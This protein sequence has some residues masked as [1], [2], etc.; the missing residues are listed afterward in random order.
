MVRYQLFWDER[1][2]KVRA[3]NTKIILNDPD[4]GG[5]DDG[6]TRWHKIK[7]DYQRHGHKHDKHHQGS[8]DQEARPHRRRPRMFMGEDDEDARIVI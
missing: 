1:E 8:E 3:K 4:E 7:Q 5:E 2:G 6:W